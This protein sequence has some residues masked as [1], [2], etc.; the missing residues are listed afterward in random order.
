MPQNTHA[1]AA[2]PNHAKKLIHIYPFFYIHLVFGFLFP[3]PSSLSLSSIFTAYLLVRPSFFFFVY[4][5]LTYFFN[6]YPGGPN[7]ATI[8]IFLFAF[9]Y[10]AAAAAVLVVWVFFS[11]YLLISF[12][13]FLSL[14][15]CV[16]FLGFGLGFVWLD[17]T[18]TATCRQE[19]LA[20]RQD[21]SSGEWG[22]S[23]VWDC[24]LAYLLT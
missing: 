5:T 20:D 23:G 10:A 17:S 11:I 6:V 9:F 1:R 22:V 24:L 19:R 14:S 4:A 16:F 18:G 8:F 15:E 21:R 3:L 2:P 7:I 13:L 12:S